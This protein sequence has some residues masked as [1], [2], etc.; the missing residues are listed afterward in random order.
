M[1]VTATTPMPSSAT[2][3]EQS[4]AEANQAYLVA[5][6]AR[7]RKQ[8]DGGLQIQDGESSFAMEPAPAIDR[9]TEVFGLTA[10]ERDLLLLCAGVEMDSALAAQCDE[11]GQ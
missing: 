8:L 9:L 2:G 3:S 10:F 1:S 6:F 4:W 5:E 7:L 11:E